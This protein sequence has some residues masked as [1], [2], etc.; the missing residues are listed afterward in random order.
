M[1]LLKR[2]NNTVPGQRLPGRQPSRERPDSAGPNRTFSYYANRSPIEGNVGRVPAVV[3]ERKRGRFKNIVRHTPAIVASFVILAC[4]INELMLGSSPRIVVLSNTSGQVF[5]R[6]TNT[7]QQAAARLLGGVSNRNKLTVDAN[8]ISVSLKRQFPEL[9][10]VSVTLPILGHRPIVYIQP[11]DP[12]LLLQTQQGLFMLD[13]SGKALL[14]ATDPT[15]FAKLGIPTVIDQSGLRIAIGHTALPSTT[16]A[17]MHTVTSQLKAQHIALQ[18]IVLPAATS[19]IDVYVSVM[20]GS[21]AYFGKF[22]T[23]NDALLQAGTFIATALQLQAQ[24]V[25]PQYIDVR[26]DGRA[27]YK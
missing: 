13:P 9:N 10:D 12:E 3:A 26:I 1:R 22:N 6:D 20:P 7:Y 18:Q 5:L 2:T 4:V 24:H 19:E 11:S 14:R 16:V 8:G 25:N 21:P 17:F 23:Q 27:Y 15:Q